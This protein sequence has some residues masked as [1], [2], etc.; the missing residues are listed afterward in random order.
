MAAFDYDRSDIPL[1][2]KESGRLRGE[3]PEP[4]LSS[5]SK[6]LSERVEMVIDLGSGTCHL[7]GAFADHSRLSTSP[8]PA[9]TV[10]V[11]PAVG[12]SPRLAWI[13]A[14]AR[15]QCHTLRDISVGARIRE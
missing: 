7:S 11:D 6:H 4:W 9:V 10:S 8:A 3:A 14:G 1:S 12:L 2:Y 15:P 13:I 5:L